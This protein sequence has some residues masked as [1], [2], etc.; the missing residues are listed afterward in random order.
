LG[1][2][3]LVKFFSMKNQELRQVPRFPL[4]KEKMKFV[5]PEGEKVFAVRDI[6]L[7]GLGISLLEFGEAV[8]FPQGFRCQAEL[9]LG[10]APL[11]V[12]V[13]V[14]RVNAWSVG[15]KFEDLSPEQTEEIRA[16]VDPLHVGSSLRAVNPK[17][18]PEAF[19]QGLGA[20]FHGDSG[21]DLFLWNEK[22]GGLK[23]ALYC[24]G[25]RFWEWDSE[26]GVATGELQRESDDKVM[27]LKDATPDPRTRAQFRKVLEHAEV[28]D[29][30]LVTF[31]KEKT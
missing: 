21:A 8:F 26:D 9:K 5:F 30:R 19:G 24:A 13:K 15:M 12:H 25:Q 14:M 6:S 4:P 28:L 31:L 20:W 7:H 27:L 16:F 23:R 10:A 18:A 1:A 29:Y 11:L 22:R 2:K 17:G 3:F